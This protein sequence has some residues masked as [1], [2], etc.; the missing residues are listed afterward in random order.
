MRWEF[1]ELS[2]LVWF[3]ISITVINRPGV[4]GA[5]LQSPPSLTH[6][7]SHGLW[8]YIQGTVNPKP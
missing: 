3:C 4:A 1:A 8:K 2:D 6:S 7:L 5:V